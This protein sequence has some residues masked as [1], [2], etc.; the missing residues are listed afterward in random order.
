MILTPP[1]RIMYPSVFEKVWFDKN[2]GVHTLRPGDP[3]TEDTAKAGFSITGLYP[4]IAKVM[5]RFPKIPKVQ[6]SINPL[7]KATADLGPLTWPKGEPADLKFP[8]SLRFAPVPDIQGYESAILIKA[9]NKQAKSIPVVDVRNA[10]ITDRA[11]I[12]PGCWCILSITPAT[13]T[14]FKG[15]YT[16]Y[17]KAIKKVGDD[18]EFAQGADPMDGFEKQN[19]QSWADD[20]P[21]TAAEWGDESQDF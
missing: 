14:T 9:T 19:D 20:V 7:K 17:L 12:Y 18:A 21:Q 5:E 16:F 10:P 3:E 6:A 13:F 4:G 1:M 11:A 2:G 15:G 8:I